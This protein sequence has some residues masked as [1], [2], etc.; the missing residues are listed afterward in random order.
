MTA[1]KAEEIKPVDS[2]KE[3]APLLRRPFTAEAVKFKVQAT[4]GKPKPTDALVVTYIDQRLVVE[5]LNLIIPDLWSD[6]YHFNGKSMI[7]YLTIDGLTRE[8]VGSGYDDGKGLYSDA[9]KRAAVKFGVGVS[10]YATPKMFLSVSDG[11]LKPRKDSLEITDSGETRCRQIY[12]KWLADHAAKAFG[13]P[14]DHGDRGDTIGDPE[15]VQPPCEEPERE[16]PAGGPPAPGDAPPAQAPNDHGASEAQRKLI[17]A[18]A[19][20][21]G[22]EEGDVRI[23]LK[24]ATGR[25]TTAGMTYVEAE[26]VLALIDSWGA[27]DKAATPTEEGN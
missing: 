21:H 15:D 23:A 27:E 25:E 2:F 7:C 9:L 11:H 18:K 14:L 8:D 6:K 22:M 1:K 17:F 16:A 5:R 12:E 3:A 4:W 24:T 13:D 20:E 10:L 19:K 26:D